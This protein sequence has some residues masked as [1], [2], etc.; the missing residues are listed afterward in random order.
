MGVLE[1]IEQR[2]KYGR[3]GNLHL[4]I[5]T[6]KVEIPKDFR[7][8]LESSKRLSFLKKQIIMGALNEGK[9]KENIPWVN[10]R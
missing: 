10:K 5:Y 4:E 9:S 2:R 6:N 3:L 8:F 7:C 1:L